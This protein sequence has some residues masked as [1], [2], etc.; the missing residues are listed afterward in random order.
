MQIPSTWPDVLERLRPKRT[1]AVVG[2]TDTGKSTFCGWLVQTL[3]EESP[4]GLVD[5]DVGQTTFGPPT[6]VGGKVFRNSA[7]VKDDLRPSALAFVGST[8]PQGHLLQTVL[9]AQQV[10]DHLRCDHA[11]RVVVDTTGKT[12]QNNATDIV[13]GNPQPG[14]T[15]DNC[16]V[17]GSGVAH[18]AYYMRGIDNVTVKNCKTD[19]TNTNWNGIFG[20]DAPGGG[21]LGLNLH[22]HGC[23]F[24]YPDLSSSSFY[25]IMVAGIDGSN[26]QTGGRITDNIFEYTGGTSGTKSIYFD[27]GHYIYTGNTFL[28]S[29]SGGGHAAESVNNAIVLPATITNYNFRY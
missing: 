3:A 16:N 17:I 23:H 22:L 26:L 19:L 1:V 29:G 9:A 18:R 5:A 25:P 28:A 6:T 11:H 24:K 14:S 13:F 10:C 27:W 4:T 20:A 8:S 7:P 15:F 2:A 21:Y 12:Y